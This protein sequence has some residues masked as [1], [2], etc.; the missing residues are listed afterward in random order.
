MLTEPSFVDLLGTYRH[1]RALGRTSVPERHERSVL[2]GL[3]ISS[4]PRFLAGS[5]SS[6]VEDEMRAGVFYSFS[7]VIRE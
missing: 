6:E 4:N 2:V 7:S 5:G 1:F 3:P